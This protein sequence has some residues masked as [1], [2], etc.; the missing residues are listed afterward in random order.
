MLHT[1]EPISSWASTTNTSASEPSSGGDRR[2]PDRRIGER[3]RDHLGGIEAGAL[4]D[5]LVVVETG[6]ESLEPLGSRARP[7]RARRR[8]THE[9]EQRAR[10]EAEAEPERDRDRAARDGVGPTVGSCDFQRYERSVSAAHEPDH[11]ADEQRRRRAP[12]PGAARGPDRDAGRDPHDHRHEVVAEELHASSSAACRRE[13]TSALIVC[14]MSTP[15]ST[16]SAAI[17]ARPRRR[18]RRRTRRRT[19]RR[20]TR[21]H[22]H[23]LGP[24]NPQQRAVHRDASA[25][26]TGTR[27]STAGRSCATTPGLSLHLGRRRRAHPVDAVVVPDRG[28][29]SRDAMPTRR[30]RRAGA[31][32]D[33]RDRAWFPAR[34]RFRYVADERRFS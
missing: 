27:R 34:V 2:Q 4:G 29:R 16:T 24:G 13:P 18:R 6:D 10:R 3:E 19:V 30:R 15:T 12:R 7:R 5:Q 9:R 23:P 17:A 14:A 1:C 22:G 28:V 31:H 33:R 32:R 20:S 26:R 8:R 25:T 11:R 21:A